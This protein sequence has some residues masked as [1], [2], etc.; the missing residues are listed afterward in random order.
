MP[1]R[2]PVVNGTLSSP[3]SRIVSSR[4]AGCL[5]GE[6]KCTPPFS[7]SRSLV[8]SSMMPWLAVTSRS[9]AISSR[10]ITPGLACGSRPVSRSTRPHIAVR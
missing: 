9:A 2:M 5:S 8:D 1:I 4:T 10:V 6:P 3:A 7:H